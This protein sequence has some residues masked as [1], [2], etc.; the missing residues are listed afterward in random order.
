MKDKLLIKIFED[1][2][3]GKLD[4]VSALAELSSEKTIEDIGIA[5]VDHGRA[6]RCGFPEFIYGEGKTASQIFEIMKRMKAPGK[7][8]LAT[9][10]SPE[11][12]AFVTK[13]LKNAEYDEAARCLFIK[14]AKRKTAKKGNILIV[15]AG[16]SRSRSKPCTRSNF[17]DSERKPASTPELPEYT[18]FFH[19][20]RNCGK[21]MS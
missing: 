12:A 21:P 6:A 4:I 1:V 2:R 9:R 7:N 16:T 10:V 20:V 19:S 5:K 17:Q 11:K 15:T 18:G 13:K 8:V 3:G 14:D